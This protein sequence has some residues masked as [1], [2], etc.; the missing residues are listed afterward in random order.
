MAVFTRKACFY[1]LLLFLTRAVDGRSRLFA[2][3]DDKPALPFV[4]FHGIGDEC[5]RTAVA[6]FVSRL[7]RDSGANGT[8]IEI[9]DGVS[10]SW[11]M[12]LE[13]Q[14]DIACTQIKAMPELQGGYNMVGL[15][16][17]HNFVS[18][19]GPHAGVASTPLCQRPAF[20]RL[21][22]AV[23]SLGIYTPYVQS[24]P[25]YYRGCQ[26]LPRLNNEVAGR[27]NAT[28]KARFSALHRLH[29]IM[30]KAD[31]VLFPR[32]TALFGFY[33]GN[34]LDRVVAANETDL[35]KEDWIG[36][37]ALDEA[38]KVQYITVPGNHLEVTEK[39]VTDFVLP[40]LVPDNKSDLLKKSLSSE[41]AFKPAVRRDEGIQLQTL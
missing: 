27:R 14:V 32:E 3:Q 33:P 29:L 17:V 28:Y 7:S 30:F 41:L 38:G 26:F 5:A 34:C 15:S 35:Y 20:C 2:E 36:L 23:I 37:R 18:M 11:T 19:G 16:Q 1:M 22:D 31:A 24:L 25:A 21:I 39:T 12:R 4:L 10:D 13:H 8:C 9:G 40:L 6:N